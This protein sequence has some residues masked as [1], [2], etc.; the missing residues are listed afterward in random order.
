MLSDRLLKNLKLE[1]RSFDIHMNKSCEGYVIPFWT[2][3]VHQRSRW[4]FYI[5]TILVISIALYCKVLLEDLNHSDQRD[6]KPE[7][8]EPLIAKVQFS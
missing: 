7:E 8:T 2:V 1:Q 3:H 5:G 4:K 6:W